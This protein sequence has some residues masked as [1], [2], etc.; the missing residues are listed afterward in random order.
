MPPNH[1]EPVTPDPKKL[2][3]TAWILVAIM[4]VGGFL[5]L[6]AYNKHTQ[7]GAKDTRPNLAFQISET[8]DLRF[9]RQDGQISDLMALKGKILVV[10]KLPLAQ[11]DPLTIAVMKRVSERFRD[12]GDVALVTLM[13]DPGPAEGLTGQLREM[14]EEIGAELPQWTVASNDRPTLHRFVKNEFKATRFPH[15]KDGRWVYDPSIVLL[16]HERHVR[17]AVIPQKR[18]GAPFITPFD[19]E[20]AQEWDA[21]GVKT[22]IDLNHVEQMEVLLI[23]TIEILLKEKEAKP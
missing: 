20:Q 14:A 2:R 3:R 5:I 22:G 17:R 21:K 6:R 16:D 11:P 4:F 19:F 23:E 8:K 18:G 1:L 7:E 13:L 9:V 10:Q 15:E 12:N